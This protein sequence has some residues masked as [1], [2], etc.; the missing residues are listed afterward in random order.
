[1][2]IWAYFDPC[3]H[4]N[5]RA[6]IKFKKMHSNNCYGSYLRLPCYRESDVLFNIRDCRKLHCINAV[7]AVLNLPSKPRILR[8]ALNMCVYVQHAFQYM[9]V[10]LF[11]G[12][13][14][15]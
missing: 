8:R 10:Y 6:Q 14:A 2:V 4:A 3:M 1:M 11:A 12:L 7:D 13:C 5:F 15:R 9:C